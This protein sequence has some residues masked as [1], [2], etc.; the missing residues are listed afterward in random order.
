MIKRDNSFKDVGVQWFEPSN[1]DECL[2]LTALGWFQ[3]LHARFWVLEAIWQCLCV[4]AET[5][6]GRT[7]D[8][9]AITRDGAVSILDVIHTIFRSPILT[10]SAVRTRFASSADNLTVTGKSILCYFYPER[11]P[12]ESTF[13]APKAESLARLISS[14]A[15]E[16]RLA[17][18]HLVEKFAQ[19]EEKNEIPKP[20]ETQTIRSLPVR[21]PGSRIFEIAWGHALPDLI[22]CLKVENER[23][24]NWRRLWDVPSLRKNQFQ[25]WINTGFLPYIDLYIWSQVEGEH[26][27]DSRLARLL[28]PDDMEKGEGNVRLTTRKNVEEFIDGE[29]RTTLLATLRVQAFLDES[30]K[31]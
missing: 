9:P 25:N 5:A 17:F 14:L 13:E 2:T 24:A 26:L 23:Q 30:R 20:Q 31:D 12:L 1:Y 11:F 28:F 16:K 4:D 15:P 3:N 7:R 10:E 29:K 6:E 22:E 19:S 27:S 21:N 18:Y 8:I